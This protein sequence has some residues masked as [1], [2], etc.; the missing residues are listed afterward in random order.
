LVSA[1]N[2][3]VPQPTQLYCRLPVV[4]VLAGE[5][6]LGGGVARDLVLHRV[7]LRAPLGVGLLDA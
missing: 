6:A 4:P 3:G 7:E 1:S 5:G 2:S